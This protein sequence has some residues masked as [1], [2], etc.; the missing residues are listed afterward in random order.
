MKWSAIVVLTFFSVIAIST[1]AQSSATDQ[2]SAQDTQVRGY[3]VDPITGLM[4]AAKDNGKDVSWKGAAKYCR[5]LQL[6][7]HSDWRLASLGELGGIYDKHAEAP[8][9][10][11]KSKWHE[12][13]PMTWHVKGNLFL[14]GDEWSSDY[15]MDDRGHNS[16]YVWYYDFNEGRSNDDPTGWPYGY[17]GMRALCVR[18]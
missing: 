10:N 11:P 8:G 2:S 5:N 14:T 12:A 15:R 17:S 7:G 4:W 9:V 13:E 18:S 3:W 6:A 1:K 16:G